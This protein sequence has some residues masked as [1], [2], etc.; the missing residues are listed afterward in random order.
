MEIIA[1]MTVTVQSVLLLVADREIN[2]RS[3]NKSCQV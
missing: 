2:F 1:K 3:S